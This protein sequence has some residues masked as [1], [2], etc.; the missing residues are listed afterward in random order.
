MSAGGGKR[1]AASDLNHDNWNDED[2]PEDAGQFAQADEDTLRGRVIKKA[3]RRGIAT[4]TVRKSGKGKIVL[5]R[6]KMLAI[7]HT[8]IQ[9]I[10][11]HIR[12]L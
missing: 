9:L 5:S 1:S 11:Q 3:K 8:Q 10:S 2:E 4:K 7:D 6:K 12:F